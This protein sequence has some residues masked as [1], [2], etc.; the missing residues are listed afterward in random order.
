MRRGA[1]FDERHFSVVTE[2]E[3]KPMI[4]G[5]HLLLEKSEVLYIPIRDKKF[6]DA[7]FLNFRRNVTEME[8]FGGRVNV[9]NKMKTCQVEKIVPGNSLNQAF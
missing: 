1:H 4:V 7:V 2:I 8:R 9:L 6:S 3:L 5:N